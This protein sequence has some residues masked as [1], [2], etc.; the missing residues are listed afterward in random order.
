MGDA[1]WVGPLVAGVAF[2]LFYGLLFPPLLRWLSGSDA[3]ITHR[4][5]YQVLVGAGA[6]LLFGLFMYLDKLADAGGIGPTWSWIDRG[7]KLFGLVCILGGVFVIG[8]RLLRRR[9]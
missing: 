6:G 5:L 8:A 7:I 2:G 3:Q 9:T 4:P 1:L